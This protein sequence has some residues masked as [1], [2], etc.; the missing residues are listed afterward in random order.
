LRDHTVPQVVAGG[1]VGGLV[2]GAVYAAFG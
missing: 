1:M 2:A